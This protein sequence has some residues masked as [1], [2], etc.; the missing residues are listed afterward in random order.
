[1]RSLPPVPASIFATG[2]RSLNRETDFPR[3][4]LEIGEASVDYRHV[5][6]E[7][8]SPGDELWIELRLDDAWV[9]AFLIEP[10]DG[11]P[12]IAE[13]RVLPYDDD[14]QRKALLGPG[15]WS[16]SDIP[17]RGVPFEKLRGLRA[18]NILRVARDSI[19]ELPEE[20]EYLTEVLADFGFGAEG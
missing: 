6:R 16:R 5:Q 20:A 11:R 14:P 10:A 19:E 15:E 1:L 18:E 2:E 4:R 9:A 7:L 12:V 8:G 3:R 17:S 13:A